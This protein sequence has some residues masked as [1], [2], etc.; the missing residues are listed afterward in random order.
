MTQRYR[1]FSPC[2]VTST[3]GEDDQWTGLSGRIDKHMLRTIAPDLHERTI[4][5]CGPPGFVDA[6]KAILA[7]L[8]FPLSQLKMESFGGTRSPGEPL[9][10]S[11][12][13]AAKSVEVTFARS[14]AS[15]TGPGRGPPKRYGIPMLL[16][17][18]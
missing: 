11:N 7:E 6:V 4:Y 13:D 18:F 17:S 3:R 14:R 8:E 9:V 10:P 12:G 2:V 5:M 16:H 1:Q 15:K